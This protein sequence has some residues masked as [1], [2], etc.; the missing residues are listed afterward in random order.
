MFD[1]PL[2]VNVLVS[3]LLLSS[4]TFPK[5]RLA[6]LAPSDTVAAWPVPE[7]LITSEE[8]VPLVVSAIDPF[9][10]EGDEGPKVALNVALP[11]AA[12]VVNVL[13]PVWLNPAP[14]TLICE[15]VSVVFPLFVSMIGCELVFP[16]VTA[17]KATL[18]GFA[19]ICACRPVPLNAIV[20]GE[21]ETLLVIEMLPKAVPPAV[22][23][24]V[25]VKEMF[26]PA[27]IDF[28]CKF[29]VYPD[30]LIVA[31]VMFRLASPSFVNVT[32]CVELLPTTTPLN[33]TGAGL[34]T[35]CGPD[36]TVSVSV[37]FPVPVPLVA[38]K[39]TLEV[40]DDVGVPEISPL[41]TLTLNPA[42]SPVAT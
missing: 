5:A 6:G 30:P 7:R 31:A 40:P 26:A 19:E 29:I 2:F 20:T 14:V 13:S 4:S 23:A 25:T 22:G 1:C 37:A 32:F 24:N 38:L 12:I 27:L 18:E 10:V 35:N 28:G 42:G 17:P 33:D 39:V 9:D 16:S 21:I 3:E 8:G 34:T 11:P 15:N 41:V 36:D